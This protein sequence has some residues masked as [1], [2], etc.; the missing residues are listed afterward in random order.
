MM[1]VFKESISQER[2]MS[3]VINFNIDLEA[4][5]LPIEIEID[6]VQ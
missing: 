4:I 3:K 6:T 1:G 5:K 2:S